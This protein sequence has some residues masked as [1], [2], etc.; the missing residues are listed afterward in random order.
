MNRRTKLKPVLLILIN[1]LEINLPFI[2]KTIPKLSIHRY[3][4]IHKIV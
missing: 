3:Y 1:N 4:Q 2:I